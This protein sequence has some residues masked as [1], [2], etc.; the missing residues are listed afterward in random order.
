MEKIEVKNQEKKEPT[1]WKKSGFCNGRIKN[2]NNFGIWKDWSRNDK[3]IIIK[4]N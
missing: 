4:K 1:R 2:N 3:M